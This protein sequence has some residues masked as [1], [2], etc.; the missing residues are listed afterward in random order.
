[1]KICFRLSVLA[2]GGTERVFLSLA[3][4]LVRRGH[5][6]DFVVDT[7]RGQGTE[8]SARQNGHNIVVLNSSRTWSSIKSFTS[9]INS[10]RPDAIISAYTET[11]AAAIFSIAMAKHKPLRVITEHASLDEH[12]ADKAWHRKLMLELIVRVVYK[13][14]DH[15]ICVSSGMATQLKERLN[16]PRIGY[17]YNPVRFKKSSRT[18]RQ[19]REI[20]G[21]DI[22]SKVVIAVGRISRQKNFIMLLRAISLIR[23]Q[24][25][26]RVYIIGGVHDQSQKDVLGSYMEMHDLGG[27]VQFVDF[28]DDITLYYEAAD[29]LALSSAWEGFG[30][31]LVEALAFGIQVV[32]TDCKHGPSEILGNGEFGELVDVD[33]FQSMASA[34]VTALNSPSRP[35]ELLKARAADFSESR[36]GSEYE[37]LLK[38]GVSNVH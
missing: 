34:L 25:G 20:L 28:T 7:V 15:V 13:A 2:F 12:W 31:V 10:S 22:N 36:I 11:N 18:K 16:H 21:I 38:L 33:D 6:V 23:N 30:N 9:Y 32:S 27:V 8:L 35:P 14:A 24:P 19:A 26:L 1:M 5:K 29:A 17:I 37:S 3:D 4:E